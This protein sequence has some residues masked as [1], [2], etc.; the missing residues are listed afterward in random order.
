MAQVASVTASLS[1]NND[2]THVAVAA[3]ISPGLTDVNSASTTANTVANKTVSPI[4]TVVRF[5]E[6]R[7]KMVRTGRMAATMTAMTLLALRNLVWE[8]DRNPASSSTILPVR[9]RLPNRRRKME[10]S[11]SVMSSVKM[12]ASAVGGL[13]VM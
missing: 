9:K 12:S 11:Q 4:L 6:L 13:M 10:A 2:G 5:T 7:M 3:K 1:K 8:Y